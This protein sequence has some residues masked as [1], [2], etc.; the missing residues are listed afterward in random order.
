MAQF[1]TGDCVWNEQTRTWVLTGNASI[2]MSGST[3]TFKG[4]TGAATISGST[5]YADGA[6]ISLGT[7]TGTKIG[8]STTQKLGFYNATPV[9]QPSST[10]NSAVTSVAGSTTTVFVN[11]TFTGGVGT[12]PYALPDI[13]ANLKNLGIIAS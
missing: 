10:G 3:G 13:V 9:V 5:T 4:P 2:D 7:T 12:T 8:T 6:N 1:N 11:T